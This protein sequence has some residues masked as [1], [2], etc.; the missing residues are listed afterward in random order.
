MPK[1]SIIIRTKNEERWISSC[2]SAIKD[3]SFKDFEIILVDNGST[4]KTISKAKK[5]DIEK[6]VNIKEYFPGK[7]I[8]MGF[9]SASGELLVCLSVHC[10]PINNNWLKNLVESIEEDDS[11]AGV[12]GRQQP[13]SFSTPSD[14][15]D[16]LLVFG[17]DRKIQIKDS[18]FHNA[19]SIIRREV[20]EKY[21]FD[22]QT[23]NIEDRIWGQTIIDNGFKILYEPSASVY[24]YHGIHQD[25]N[26]E[27]LINIVNIIE[28][29]NLTS[30]GF[31]DAN[32]FNTVAVIPIKGKGLQINKKPLIE[33]TINSA[34]ESKYVN[35]VIVSTDD[36]ETAKIA[37]SLGAS[38]PFIRPKELSEEHVNLEKVQQYSLMELEKNNIFPDLF[39]HLEETYPFRPPFIIDNMISRLLDKGYDTVIASKEELGWLWSQDENGTIR[40]I[41]KGDIPRKFKEKSIKGLHGLACISHT[42]FIRKGNLL[43][44]KIGLFNIES[45]LADIEV[46]NIDSIKIAERIILDKKN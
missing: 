25:S 14:K 39:V 12:Y 27:R 31:L 19:N 46:N 40:R 2:L 41:D 45:P 7:A 4:D 11:Y 17:L 22:S 43:G 23:T 8:N 18:F 28:K 9:E 5:F 15:R 33:I 10:I 36:E 44:N 35:Q 38:C 16:L 3:Q 24:H 1:V 37:Q 30:N 13:M 29:N 42:E 6:I 34:L 21:P 26:Q 32:K 20:W